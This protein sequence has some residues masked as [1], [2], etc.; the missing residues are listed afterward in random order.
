LVWF[1]LVWFGLV[2]FGLVWFGLVWFGGVLPYLFPLIYLE[3][4]IC[5]YHN[6]TSKIFVKRYSTLINLITLFYLILA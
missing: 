4:T 1:G 2:W 5:Y 6:S 3:G